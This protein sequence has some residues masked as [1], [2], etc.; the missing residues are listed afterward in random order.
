MGGDDAEA[1]ANQ[2]TSSHHL[3]ARYKGRISVQVPNCFVV[4]SSL[5]G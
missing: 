5:T 3:P 2:L 4:D 1:A